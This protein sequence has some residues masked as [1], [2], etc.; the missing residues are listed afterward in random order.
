MPT[1]YD[2]AQTERL[3]AGLVDQIAGGFDPQQPLIVIGIRTRGETLA[4]R[5]T[6]MLAGRG[7]QIHRGVL[8]ITLYR[9]DLSEVGPL[10]LVRPTKID[11]DINGKP[12]LLVDDVLF[13]GRTVRAALDALRDFGRPKAIRLAAFVDRGGRELP[14]QADFVGLTKKDVPI[15]HRVKVKLSETDGSDEIVIE[16]RDADRRPQ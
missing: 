13:T 3:L 6:P 4:Q 5:I 9:D 15:T 2:Q 8:D 1:R 12:L 10:P 7:F 14:I 16:P 11:V